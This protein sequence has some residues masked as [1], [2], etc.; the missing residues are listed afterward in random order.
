MTISLTVILIETTGNISFAL[1]L[2]ITLI[3]AKWMGDYINEGI[4]DTLISISKVPMLPW[5]VNR[6]IQTLKASKI[7]NTPPACLR[8]KE[9]S[10]YIINMLKTY[11]YNGFP[12]VDEVHEVCEPNPALGT[13][14]FYMNAFID[15]SKQRTSAWIYST[16]SADRYIKTWSLRRDTTPLAK[17]SHHRNVP[18]RISKIYNH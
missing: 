14:N 3:S 8:L 9:K 12:V 2:I 10:S 18:Q 4:Y 7:M 13:V 5:N 16:V 15:E 6:D 11:S 1:P 17:R